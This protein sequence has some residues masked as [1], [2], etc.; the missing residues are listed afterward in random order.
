MFVFSEPSRSLFGFSSFVSL[1]RLLSIGSSD[2]RA[3]NSASIYNA[4]QE[5]CTG[6]YVLLSVFRF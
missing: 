2:E 5:F 3:V 6:P 4:N 1:S